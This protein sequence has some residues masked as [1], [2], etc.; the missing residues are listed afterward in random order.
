MQMCHHLTNNWSVHSCS[1]RGRSQNNGL[2][3]DTLFF[4]PSLVSA[5]C[6]SHSV[7]SSHALCKML[8]STYLA[9]KTPVMQSLCS[10]MFPSLQSISF[11]KLRCSFNCIIL[12]N[13]RHL[14][15]FIFSFHQYLASVGSPSLLLQL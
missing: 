4:S 11:E 14:N 6:L 2:V 9:H 7:C 1:E 5:L 15:T 3:T 10:S 8:F 13:Y 12:L